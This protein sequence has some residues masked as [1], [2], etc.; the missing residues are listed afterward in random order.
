MGIDLSMTPNRDSLAFALSRAA[1]TLLLEHRLSAG[2]LVSVHEKVKAD[3][4]FAA[5]EKQLLAYAC[6]VALEITSDADR[7]SGLQTALTELTLEPLDDEPS[8]AA[9]RV[10]RGL[11]AVFA[12]S[13][14]RR[15]AEV[16]VEARPEVELVPSPL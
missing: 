9:P 8:T 7:R 3:T 15:T 5:D 4:V 2:E 10:A 13:H 11:E 14:R 16:E 1:D 12:D 6:R